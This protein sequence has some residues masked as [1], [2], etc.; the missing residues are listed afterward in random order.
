MLFAALAFAPQP[1]P[2]SARGGVASVQPR[3]CTSADGDADLISLS[4]LEAVAD[5]LGCKL[6]VNSVGPAYKLELLWGSQVAKQLIGGDPSR[7]DLLGASDGF[8][9]PTGVVHLE[10]IQLR[11]FTGYWRRSWSR[12]YEEVP[13]LSRQGLGLL[14]SVAVAAWI[15]ERDPFGCK[16][17]QLLAIYDSEE[18]HKTLV[19][20]YRR[21]GFT[22]MREVGDDWRGAADRMVSGAAALAPLPAP[23]PAASPPLSSSPLAPPCCPAARH[24][25]AMG[26]FSLA[27]APA[28]VGR[29]GHSDGGGRLRVPRQVGRHGAG[30]ASHG[31]R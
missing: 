10:T 25:R 17:A 5:R 22:T 18:Q 3:L 27:R 9:Q 1:R 31:A 16:R 24:S 6:Q 23:R 19:R 15:R 21:L 11:R 8:S 28:G 7:P 14:L 12:R 26:R 4:E 13:R 29:R 30:D 2:T 20:Y